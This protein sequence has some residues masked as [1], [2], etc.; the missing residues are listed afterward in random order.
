[1]IGRASRARAHGGIQGD[2]EQKREQ[3]LV[4][5]RV[6][7]EDLVEREQDGGRTAAPDG[8]PEP[9]NRGIEDERRGDSHHV[10][11]RD[12]ELDLVGDRVRRT[13]E[14]QVADRARRVAE[15]VALG[16][17]HV[18]SRV[19]EVDDRGAVGEPERQPQ[20]DPE[21]H[22]DHDRQR[23]GRDE[24]ARADA[25]ARAA[26]FTRTGPRTAASGGRGFVSAPG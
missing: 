3:G 2:D 10:L 19:R 25:R 26:S 21:D 24:L 12:R 8:R 18:A 16:E 23:H 15:Q 13:Q 9:A 22:Q 7:E 5:E 17:A 14:E 4:H 6:L 20:R 1:M 11:K